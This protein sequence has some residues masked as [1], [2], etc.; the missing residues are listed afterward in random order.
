MR[1]KI[2]ATLGPSTENIEAL[3]AMVSYGVR[4]FRLNFSHATAEDFR[5][6]IKII[7]E[8][9][10]ELDTPLT[11][12]GD[13]CGPKTRIGEIKGSPLQ[14]N[15]GDAAILG[16]PGEN[17]PPDMTY[18]SL[19]FPELLRNLE[20]GMPVSLSDGMLRFT[21][22]EILKPDRLFRLRAQNGGLLT[23]NKGITFP[24][25][26]HPIRAMT[27]KDKKDLDEGLEIGLDAVAQSFIQSPEDMVELR[28]E[29]ERRGR[30]IPV[31]A[32]IERRNALE[33][34]EAIID[35]S[36]AVMVARGDLGLECSLAEVPV[37]QKRIA[38]ACRHHQKA[39]IIATQMLLSMVKN[40]LPT[41]AESSDVANAILDGSD[42]VMLSEETAIGQYPVEA[43]QFIHE[44]AQS[45]EAYYLER[46]QGPF[47]PAKEKNPY[48]YMAYAASLL[49]ENIEAAGLVCHSTSGRT[50]RL[51]SSRKPRQTIYALT[52]AERVVRALNFFWGVKPTSVEES[53]SHLERAEN[54]I[55]RN[56]AFRPG[57]PVVITSGEATPGHAE[58][59][60]NLIKLYYK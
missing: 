36:D 30:R 56:E 43:V 17:P 58:P 47:A 29:I 9:E 24:G 28:E 23:S 34:L 42:C 19:N 60:T 53:G 8:V 59:S 10:H 2:I 21:V 1:T 4:I 16:L 52:P 5:P 14:V 57:D 35:L 27:V 44:L 20:K 46:A 50:A 49:A 15:Q 54:F 3:R 39:V 26:S 25:K 33:N 32:K 12:M 45:A 55:Q 11:A 31:V 7:R 48:K 22:E 18:I 40:P 6:V 51:L 13:L 37:I 41:R 38:R